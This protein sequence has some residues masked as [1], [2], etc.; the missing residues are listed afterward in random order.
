MRSLPQVFCSLNLG[1]IY[2]LEYS[3]SPD[4]GTKIKVYFVN[5]E[6]RYSKPSLLPMNKAFIQIGGAHFSMY[7]VDYGIE[8]DSGRRIIWVE[9]EDEFLFLDHYYVA[10]PGRG[11]GTNV[12][13][14]GEPVDNRSIEQKMAD[15]LD[16]VA[17]KIEQLTQF[18]DYAYTFDQFLELLR[19][20]FSVQVSANFDSTYK[21][22]FEGP[23][24]SILGDWCDLYNLSF[25]FENGIIKIFDPT[26]LTITLP[27]QTSEML[28][29]SEGESIRDTYG[30]TV[31]SWFQQDGDQYSLSQASGGT[32]NPNP[33]DPASNGPLYVRADTL[34]PAGYEFNLYQPTLD[35]NQVAAAQYGPQ[36]WFLYNYYYGSVADNCGWSPIQPSATLDISQSVAAL[37]PGVPPASMAKIAVVNTDVQEAKY[38]AFYEYGKNIAGRYYLSNRKD[39]LAIERNFTWFDESEGQIFNF[40]NVDD[41]AMNLEFLTP[42]GA[43]NNSID[44]TVINEY[45]PGVNYVGN[46]MVYKDTAPM[47]SGAFILE[48]GLQALVASTYQNIYSVKAGESVDFNTELAAVYSGYNTYV[49]YIPWVTVPQELVTKFQQIPAEAKQFLSPRFP[50]VPIKGVS[51]QDYSAIKSSQ[52][53]PEEVK[54]VKSSAGPGVVSNTSVIKTEREGSYTVYYDK[55]SQCASASTPDSYYAF[56]FAPQQVSTDNQFGVTFRKLAGN[57][58]ALNRNYAVIDSLVNNPL[59]STLAQPRTF[60]TK[61]VSY[62]KNFFDTIPTN[63][64]SNGLVGMSMSISDNGTSASYTYSNEV[65]R[66]PD[67]S[68]EFANLQQAMKNSWI[69]TYRPNKTILS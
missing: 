9:F 6:G 34:Y 25:F 67:R 20:K 61:H 24:I 68:S 55:Y 52:I 8:S 17:T 4:S 64:L 37:T 53:E 14:L 35:A 54:I 40:S 50:A 3:Y 11:C 43:G 19:T 27:T 26:T 13:T 21:R 42:V 47:P 36:F 32:N 62:T 65:L 30:K 22:D 33:R 28:S 1:M 58:Y 45:Y 57:T 7:P 44:G 66:L 10:L 51:S 16:P 2:S 63:F 39:S 56:R 69:R 49:A 46:R 18:P 60:T 15:S 48:G 5:R 29:F 59:L 12:F 31:S 41:K 38:Q 23:F